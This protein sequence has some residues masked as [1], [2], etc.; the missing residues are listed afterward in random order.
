MTEQRT[1]ATAID[2]VR[3]LGIFAVVVG[4]VWSTTFVNELVYPWHVPVFFFLTGYLWKAGRSLKLEVRSRTR[5]LLVPYAAWLVIIG[6]AFFVTLAAT[7]ETF[8]LTAVGKTIYGGSFATRPFSAFWFVT[9]LFFAA[10]FLRALERLG[11]WAQWSIAVLGLAVC[12]VAGDKVAE[13]PLAI[14]VAVPCMTFILAGV[15]FRR[16]RARITNPLLVGLLMLA[17][18][19]SLVFTHV[20]TPLDLK[21]GY[22]G[23]PVLGVCVAVVI[24]AGFLL[25]AESVL[26]TV[27]AAP[28][29][30]IV[31][32]AQAGLVVV[33][34]HAVVLW[35][36]KTPATG[37][38]VALVL[39]LVCSWTLGLVVIHSRLSPLLAGQPRVNAPKVSQLE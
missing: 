37:S 17:F 39:C 23:V 15:E 24:S 26:R 1:R 20:S 5:S 19:F 18:G 22:F 35:I 13:L 10:V 12:A 2:A 16:L 21:Y 3:V 8:G 33:L 14:G 25:V 27:T 38:V 30:A 11:T 34:T 32:L 7:S 31:R 6:V 9:A 28:A 4:H 29:T 36:L